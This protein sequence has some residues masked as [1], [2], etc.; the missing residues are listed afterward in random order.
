MGPE[1]TVDFYRQVIAFTP[2]GCDQ[3]HIP[4]VILSHTAVPDRTESIL[5]GHHHSLPAL[6]E[7]VTFL[8]HAGA[9]IIAIPCNTAHY[10]IEDL[11]AGVRVPI[12]SIIEETVSAIMSMPEVPRCVAIFGTDG[13]RAAH[14]YDRPLESRGIRCIFP[15]AAPQRRIMEIIGRIKAGQAGSGERQELLAFS[16]HARKAGAEALVLGCTELPL[17]FR[18]HRPNLA[19]LDSTRLLA[20]AAVR[21]CLGSGLGAKA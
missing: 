14:L 13:V 21:F 5:Q 19:L 3:E 11:R 12:L 16:E 8:E 10:Y 7:G 18:G 6:I 17:L 4:T 1:A 20:E 15:D 2:A 9:E